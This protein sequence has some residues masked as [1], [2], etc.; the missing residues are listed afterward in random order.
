[1][2][3]ERLIPQIEA[4]SRQGLGYEDVMVKLRIDPCNMHV[5][6]RTVLGIGHE[7]QRESTRR[8]GDA[9]TR[10]ADQ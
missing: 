9:G 1:M 10:A 7:H 8:H 3:I 2:I 4:L 5:V 6:R